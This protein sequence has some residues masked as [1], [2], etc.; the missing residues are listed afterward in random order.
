M[1]W[2]QIFSL[3]LYLEGFGS[4]KGLQVK[5]EVEVCYPTEKFMGRDWVGLMPSPALQSTRVFG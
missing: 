4:T 1:F 5:D 3:W 2:N